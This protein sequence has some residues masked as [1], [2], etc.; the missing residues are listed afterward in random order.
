MR[1]D[2][3]HIDPSKARV[4]LIEGSPRILAAYP[5]D[6]SKKAVQQLQQ[7]GVEV[8]AGTSVTDVKPGYVVVGG[9]RMDAVVTLWAAGVQA[10]PAGQNAG[11]ADG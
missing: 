8:R 4:I 1:H 9:K 7:L 10:S 5:E 3:R 2:F 11:R 6:L